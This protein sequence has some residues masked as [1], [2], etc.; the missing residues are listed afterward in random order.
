MTDSPAPTRPRRILVVCWGVPRPDTNSADRRLVGLLRLMC[1]C[2]HVVLCC[3]TSEPAEDLLV[4][5]RYADQLRELGVPRAHAQDGRVR[6]VL[7]SSQHK[8]TLV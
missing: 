5:Q 1:R 6:P 7:V 3:P 2:H 4:S 8:Q